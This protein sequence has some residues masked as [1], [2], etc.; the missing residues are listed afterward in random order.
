MMSRFYTFMIAFF[1]LAPDF[2]LADENKI[3]PSCPG[4]TVVWVNQNTGVYHLPGD[5]WYGRTKHGAYECEKQAEA[6][7]A[8]RSGARDGHHRAVT[9]RRKQKGRAS[10]TIEDQMSNAKPSSSVEN[11]F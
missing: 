2:A 7:G 5:R 1:I 9:S 3:I 4:D 8:H 10:S 6:E 11:P